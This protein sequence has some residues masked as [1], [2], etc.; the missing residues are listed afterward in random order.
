MGWRDKLG[1]QGGGNEEDERPP[2]ER[3]RDLRRA[4]H[5]E[6][7]WKLLEPEVRR[8]PQD[9]E[10]SHLFWDLSVQMDRREEGAATYARIISAEL[11]SDPALGVFHWFELVDRYGEEPPISLDLRVKLA[12]AMTGG[13]NEENAADLLARVDVPDDAPLPQR[14]ALAKAAARCRAA[15]TEELARPLLE[16]PQLPEGHKQELQ[17]LVQQAKSEGLRIAP[18]E[19]SDAPIELSESMTMERTLK[20]IP[21][22]P[23]AI[24]GETITIE[25]PGQGRRRMKLDAV[26]ALATAR[27]DSGTED[28]FV[29]M[30]LL[31]DSLWSD[32]ETLRSVRFRSDQFDPLPLAPDAKDHL[33]GLVSLIQSI[34]AV[35]RAHP[36]PDPEAVAGRPFRAF[37]SLRAYEEEVLEMTSGQ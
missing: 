2:V 18:G 36:L 33:S 11:E 28:P 24:D 22:L 23:R 8:N 34:L 21:S 26:Q 15:S 32:K 27:I 13:E 29:V 1:G 7:A 31:V 14:L 19:H 4:G 3:A 12:Q 20:V 6:Q 5:Y 37:P 16:N 9:V 10:T 30:D 25:V 35:S 17:G